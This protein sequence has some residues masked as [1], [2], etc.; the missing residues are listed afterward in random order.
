MNLCVKQANG[1]YRPA[2]TEEIASAAADVVRDK[3]KGKN[4]INSPNQVKQY[5]KMKLSHYPYEVFSCLFLDNQHH[6]LEYK[7]IFRGTIN[8]SAVYPREIVREAMACNAAAVIFAHNHPS[9]ESTPSEADIKITKRLDE[10]L[11]FIDVRVL[12]HIV[13]GDDPASL[14]ELGHI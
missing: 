11:G 8:G 6:I 14:A 1:R 2:T 10:A 7:E 3:L 13:V 5:F 9:G 12:D 4:A